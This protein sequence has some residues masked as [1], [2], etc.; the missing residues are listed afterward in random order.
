MRENPTILAAR[1]LARLGAVSALV[2]CGGA[3]DPDHQARERAR[4]ALDCPDPS[5]VRI[6]ES[7]Y[8]ASGCGGSVE[9]LC[10]AGHNEPVCIAGRARD[11]FRVSGLVTASVGGERAAASDSDESSAFSE[12]ADGPSTNEEVARI[13]RTIRRGLEARRDDVLACTG[14]TASVVRVRYAVDGSI[15]LRLAGDLEGSPE[16][17]CV[18][19]A[20]G[21]V[22][23]EPG[24]AG[25]VLHLLRRLEDAT[26]PR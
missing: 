25:V 3:W 10:T 7:R 19:A 24:R 8:R 26:S 1:L 23:V 21:N 15:E 17:G 9:V 6:A 5:V 2:A 22:R 20:L 11:E 16:E 12:D 14:R 13:E 4:I 18:R